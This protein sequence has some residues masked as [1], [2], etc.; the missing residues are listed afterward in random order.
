MSMDQINLTGIDQ[1]PAG[2]N[3]LTKRR[4]NGDHHEEMTMNQQVS[5]PDMTSEFYE[6]NEKR[7]KS[8]VNDPEWPFVSHVEAIPR[9]G[10]Q[11]VDFD[12]K[13]FE[14]RIQR[15]VGDVKSAEMDYAKNQGT[16]MKGEKGRVKKIKKPW[17][18]YPRSLDKYLGGEKFD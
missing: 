8:V 12:D 18:S 11:F 1:G 6:L 17:K 14:I 7:R 13:N 5:G 3:S 9:S 10:R 2:E 16:L 4:A 15:S